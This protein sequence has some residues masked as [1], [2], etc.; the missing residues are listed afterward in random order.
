MYSGTFGVPMLT[1]TSVMPELLPMSLVYDGRDVRN[2]SMPIEEVA[3]ALQGF[4]NAYGKIAS[5]VDS[6]RTHQI[7]VTMLAS[8]PSE[9]EPR[10]M[11]PGASGYIDK[12]QLFEKLIPA[13]RE[14]AEAGL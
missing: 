7:R 8:D 12:M 10:A 1:F 11:S 3:V 9:G 2:G 4:S 6:Q 14:I 5:E 13:L